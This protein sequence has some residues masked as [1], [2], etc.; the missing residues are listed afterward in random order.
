MHETLESIMAEL[1]DRVNTE[2]T[3]TTVTRAEIEEQIPNTVVVMPEWSK[4][5][6]DMLKV[7]NCYGVC[8]DYIEKLK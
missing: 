2:D 8:S 3:E 6:W 4:M 5:S 7:T 1:R